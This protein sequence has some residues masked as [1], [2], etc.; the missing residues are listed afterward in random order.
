MSTDDRIASLESQ[1]RTLKRMLLGC[2]AVGLAAGLLAAQGTGDGKADQPI[3]VELVGPVKVDGV[4]AI[5][6][7]TVN[8]D[9]FGDL[10]VRLT[11]YVGIK[12]DVPIVN[13]GG[14]GSQ[15]QVSR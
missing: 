10:P 5:V 7:H 2:I 3:K 12:G 11:G 13:G 6:T 15:F 4:G 14:V 9:G 1:V 8:W